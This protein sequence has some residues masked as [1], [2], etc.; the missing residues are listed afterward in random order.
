MEIWIVPLEWEG[1]IKAFEWIEW[2][3]EKIHWAFVWRVRVSRSLSLC[4]K[5]KFTYMYIRYTHTIGSAIGD[6]S[7]LR[8]IWC[9]LVWMENNFLP[10]WRRLFFNA[11]KSNLVFIDVCAT[12]PLSVLRF[13]R[14]R[15]LW[16]LL[17]VSACVSFF[18]S[19]FIFKLKYIIQVIALHLNQFRSHCCY[20]EKQKKNENLI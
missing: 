19:S 6:Y 5:S 8:I 7:Q 14:G 10:N 4:L 9:Y 13:A 15:L 1:K 2:R 12:V 11:I 20:C 3:E 16:C 17:L 18:L